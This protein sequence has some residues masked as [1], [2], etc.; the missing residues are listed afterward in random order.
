M[1]GV[2]SLGAG[3]DG[4][5]GNF[6]L[7]RLNGRKLW[8]SFAFLRPLEASKRK[9]LSKGPAEGGRASLAGGLDAHRGSA[10][11]RSHGKRERALLDADQQRAVAE[12][13]RSGRPEAWTALYD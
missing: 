10:P 5:G 13:L 8:N 4:G 3:A 1:F 2:T 9:G 7:D 11:R 12:G 6:G